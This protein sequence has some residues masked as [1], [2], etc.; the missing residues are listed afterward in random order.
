MNPEIF[1]S[2]LLLPFVLRKDPMI[3]LNPKNIKNT[4]KCLKSNN[5]CTFQYLENFKEIYNCFLRPLLKSGNSN[6]HIEPFT[7]CYIVFSPHSTKCYCI[8]TKHLS[9]NNFIYFSSYLSDTYYYLLDNFE[10]YFGYIPENNV[11]IIKII[12]V[13]V[14]QLEAEFET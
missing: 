14:K 2:T 12:D 1:Y 5:I 9:T 4:I 3:R 13:L 7:D 6:I 8:K 11:H 10:Y